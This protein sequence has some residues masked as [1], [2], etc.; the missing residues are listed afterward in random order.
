MLASVSGDFWNSPWIQ[1]SA[2]V[3]LDLDRPI[4]FFPPW[5]QGPSDPVYIRC[6]SSRL[7]VKTRNPWK[8]GARASREGEMVAPGTD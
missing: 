5:C 8:E 2:L 6:L 1:I 3:T 7:E 4:T